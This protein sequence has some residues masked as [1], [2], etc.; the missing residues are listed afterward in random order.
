MM[1][2]YIDK[3]IL[4]LNTRIYTD[5]YLEGGFIHGLDE[6]FMADYSYI[7]K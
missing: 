7:A 1:G 4:Q 3:Y 5:V 2:L 6:L